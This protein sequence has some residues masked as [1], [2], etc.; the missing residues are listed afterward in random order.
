[1]EGRPTHQDL[2]QINSELKDLAKIINEVNGNQKEM[3]G[4]FKHVVASLH[5]NP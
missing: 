4:A 2:Q 1:L 5:R 3:S